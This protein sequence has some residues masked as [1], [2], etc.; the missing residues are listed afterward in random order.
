MSDHKGAALI[1]PMLPDAET[2]NADKGY[3]SDASERLSP[4]AA[5]R[6][7]FHREPS[8]GCRN[9]LQDFVPTA[10]QGREHVRKAKRLA[11]HLNALRPLRPHVLQRYL[12]HGTRYPLARP[13]SP[14]P[15]FRSRATFADRN[16]ERYAAGEVPTTRLKAT[17]K[18]SRDS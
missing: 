17:R 14:D 15:S 13:M 10:P 2:V 9:I 1:Y 12:H 7:A 3:D 8:A 11:A 5:L 4:D 6:L 16:L 18:V